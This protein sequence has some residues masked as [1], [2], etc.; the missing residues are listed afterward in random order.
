MC[1]ILFVVATISFPK[2]KALITNFADFISIFLVPLLLRFAV[3]DQKNTKQLHRN[4]AIQPQKYVVKGDIRMS[5]EEVK[6]KNSF[7]QEMI[8]IIDQSTVR[9]NR[10][11]KAGNK[12]SYIMNE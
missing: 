3:K 8:T 9:Y 11:S 5:R 4:P 1:L 7:Q 2:Q 12:N 10:R 6:N